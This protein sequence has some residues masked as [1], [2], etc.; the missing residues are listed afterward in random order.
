M[1]LIILTTFAVLTVW[2]CKPKTPTVDVERLEIALA[3]AQHIA[4]S[5]KT[6]AVPLASGV[7]HIVFL[8][9]KPEITEAEKAEFMTITKNL[10]RIAEVKAMNVAERADT[11]DKRALDYDVVLYMTFATKEDLV[12]YDQNKFHQ[13]VRQQLGKYLAAAPATFDYVY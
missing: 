6:A 12:V 9:L 5:L 8:D 1:K 10:S 4:D 11:G 13:E 3:K 2:S 7:R